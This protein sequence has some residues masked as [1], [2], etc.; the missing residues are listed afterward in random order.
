MVVRD[1][2]KSLQNLQIEAVMSVPPLKVTEARRVR[3]V[4][5]TNTDSFVKSKGHW[6]MLPN[7][8][9]L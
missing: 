1:A 4:L 9:L 2:T 8:S 7:S 3:H 5:M 6:W